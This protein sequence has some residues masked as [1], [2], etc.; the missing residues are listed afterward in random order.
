MNAIEPVTKKHDARETWSV[1]VVYENT[2]TRERAMAVCDHLVQQFWSEVEFEFNWWRTDFLEEPGM[3][4]TAASNAAAADFIIFCAGIES[5]LAR[6]LGEWCES[7]VE[8]RGSREGVLVDLTQAAGTA[9][10]RAPNAQTYL[11]LIARRAMMDYLTEVPATIMGTLPDSF[12]SA[13]L[14]ATHI[15]SVLDDI[16]HHSPPP[17]HYG[18]NE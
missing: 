10:S 7:W 4:A 5:E 9:A 18:L 17:S 2:A 14:R 15:S 6:P 11:R 1:V 12:E 8:R 3:A 16:L 13:A